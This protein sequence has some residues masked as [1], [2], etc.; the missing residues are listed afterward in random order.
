[1]RWTDNK[2]L[3]WQFSDQNPIAQKLPLAFAFGEIHK[4]S[5]EAFNEFY[6]TRS[7]KEFDNQTLLS[8]VTRVNISNW[9]NFIK[10]SEENGLSFLDFWKEHGN[11]PN[12]T[13]LVAPVGNG[14]T[15]YINHLLKIEFPILFRNTYSIKSI[16]FDVRD[17]IDIENALL[18]P[19]IFKH[20]NDAIEDLCDCFGNRHDLNDFHNKTHKIEC[21]LF[22][23][24][25]TRK[26]LRPDLSKLDS[27][28]SNKKYE[29][30]DTFFEK[31]PG[32]Y[33][34]RKFRYVYNKYPN[35]FLFL[36]LIILITMR[37]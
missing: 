17:S 15:T 27:E 31:F 11:V 5:D 12:V 2:E 37:T 3:L 18:G 30:I 19:T 4:L 24:I 34:N 21:S 6:V 35:F 28:D 1:M 29:L 7:A 20:L 36:S 9:D 10:K 23:D 13:Q 25:L 16:I 32:E 26:R 33:L 14:K 8:D 22:A